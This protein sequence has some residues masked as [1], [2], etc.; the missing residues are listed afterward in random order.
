MSGSPLSPIQVHKNALFYS[1]RDRIWLFFLNIV[2]LKK[3]N[4]ISELEAVLGIIYRAMF[5][6]L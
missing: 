5:L 2:F 1:Q 4:R 6:K 3:A